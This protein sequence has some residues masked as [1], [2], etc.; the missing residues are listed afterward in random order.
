MSGNRDVHDLCAMG[1]VA[2]ALKEHVRGSDFKGDG[3]IGPVLPELSF[4]DLLLTNEVKNE[5]KV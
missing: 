5:A 3:S 4:L 2:T 1:M